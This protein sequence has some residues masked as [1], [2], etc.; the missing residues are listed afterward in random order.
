MNEHEKRLRDHMRSVAR[1][2]YDLEGDALLSSVIAEAREDGRAEMKEEAALLCMDRC[3]N[4]VTGAVLARLIRELSTT[5][6]ASIPVAKVREVLR[7]VNGRAAIIAS[8]RGSFISCVEAALAEVEDGLGVP[9]DGGEEK[10]PALDATCAR[11]FASY[12]THKKDGR[13]TA[14]DGER[15][16]TLCVGFRPQV[17]PCE[18]G[19]PRANHDDSGRI[20][21]FNGGNT[22]TLC[23]GFRANGVPL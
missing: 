13:R 2:A 16:A 19:E 18:C 8:D 10:G 12:D 20:V 21:K 1:N 11:C 22:L 3:M 4:K 9:I 6:P 14:W 5:P 7:R 17:T 23:A 15:E